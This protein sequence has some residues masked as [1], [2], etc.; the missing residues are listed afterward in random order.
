[1]KKVFLLLTSMV[2]CFNVYSQDTI[3]T[4]STPKESIGRVT[5]DLSGETRSFQNWLGT[6][7]FNAP[8]TQQLSFTNFTSYSSQLRNRPETT[9]YLTSISF[10]NYEVSPRFV[11]SA[12][13]QYNNNFTWDFNVSSFNVKATYRVLK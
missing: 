5:W 3:T 8:L 6:S 2:M 1:M 4:N 9:S 11:I 7:N 10:I 13:Y 12:G